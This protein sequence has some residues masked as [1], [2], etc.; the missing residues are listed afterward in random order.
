MK[1]NFSLKATLFALTLIV[2]GLV[3]FVEPHLRIRRQNEV[4]EVMLSQSDSLQRDNSGNV[5]TIKCGLR[6]HDRGRPGDAVGILNSAVVPI[7]IERIGALKKLKNLYLH[8][9]TFGSLEP[10]TKLKNLETLWVYDCVIETFS[11]IP[12]LNITRF[13]L[14]NEKQASQ[15]P[16]MPK[17]KHL[18]LGHSGQGYWLTMPNAVIGRAKHLPPPPGYDFHQLNNYR[19]ATKV[20]LLLLTIRNF[21]GLDQFENLESLTLDGCELYSFEGIEKLPSLTSIEITDISPLT[22]DLANMDLTPLQNCQ[23]LKHFTFPDSTPV[24]VV[25]K[26]QKAL[27]QID[28]R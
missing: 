4:I 19:T 17:L 7:P 2:I 23:I 20:D 18:T 12:Q 14:N 11:D 13:I 26:F 25:R 10:I 21:D 3:F 9:V 24:E 15:F 8:K 22:P 16:V 27:P 6:W 1:F 28:C 5:T